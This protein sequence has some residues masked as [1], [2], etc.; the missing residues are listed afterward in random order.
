MMGYKHVEVVV[1]C[2]TGKAAALSLGKTSAQTITTIESFG[3][4]GTDQN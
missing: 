4:P 2:A 3:V 1:G